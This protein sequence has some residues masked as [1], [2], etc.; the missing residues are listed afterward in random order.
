MKTEEELN[1]MPLEDVLTL[2]QNL[3]GE[4][5]ET[6]V[7]EIAFRNAGIGV[8]FYEPERHPHKDQHTPPGHFFNAPSIRIRNAIS[9][10]Q[11]EDCEKDRRLYPLAPAVRCF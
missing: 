9:R 10:R 4:L 11:S 1:A 7:Y 8:M 2:I 5:G 6:V 3:A